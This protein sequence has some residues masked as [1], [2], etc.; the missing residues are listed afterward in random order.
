MAFQPVPL[1][2]HCAVRG[3]LSDGH[4]WQNG[5]WF[6][7]SGVLDQS[8]AD[9]LADLL[10]AAYDNLKSQWFTGTRANDV[11]VTDRRTEGAPQFV[12][13]SSFPIVGTDSSAPLPSQASALVSWI[14]DFRGKAGRGRSFIPGFTEAASAGD[15]PTATCTGHLEDFADV[16][17]MSF[18]M[19]SLFLGNTV[20]TTG[21]LRK[22]PTPRAAGV[23]HPIT[24][25]RV[26]PAWATQRRRA[27]K[28]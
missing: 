12:S 6:S 28:V 7:S 25:Y 26:A 11:L 23:L 9:T 20:A 4:A 17:V 3:T 8:D 19:A 2:L 27:I 13:T 24:G 14:T 16:I 22:K 5:F 18:A 21:R 10:S 1:G 15:A